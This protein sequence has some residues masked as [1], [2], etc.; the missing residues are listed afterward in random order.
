MTTSRECETVP[1]L[2]D[3]QTQIRNSSPDDI[4]DSISKLELLKLL[5]TMFLDSGL[6]DVPKADGNEKTWASYERIAFDASSSSVQNVQSSG[7]FFG[8]A[9]ALGNEIPIY[10]LKKHSS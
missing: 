2:S 7:S 5:P 9:S 1:S 10:Y 4:E 3:R 8:V 6:C